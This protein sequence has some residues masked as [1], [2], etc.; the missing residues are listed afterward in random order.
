VQPFKSQQHQ[1]G[2]ELL[3]EEHLLGCPL[4]FFAE[5][6]CCYLQLELDFAKQLVPWALKR[7]VPHYQLWREIL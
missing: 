6:Q 1:D 3:C 5:A 7:L 4:L 2:Q